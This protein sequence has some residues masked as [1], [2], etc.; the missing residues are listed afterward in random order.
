MRNYLPDMLDRDFFGRKNPLFGHHKKEL[1]KTVIRARK[2]HYE[3]LVDLPGFRKEDIQIEMNNGYLTINA[4]KGFDKEENGEDGSVIRQERYADA[5]SRSFYIGE[6]ISQNDIH[7]T[8]DGG[9]LQIDV[10]KKE[11]Q[12]DNQNY[13][14][15]E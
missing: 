13:I 2:D 6:N 1:M 4:Q 7:A 11:D 10:P 9:V 5:L 15:I 12:K 8:L 14:S 3:M